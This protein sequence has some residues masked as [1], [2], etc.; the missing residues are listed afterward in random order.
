MFAYRKLQEVAHFES[1]KVETIQH[2]FDRS[3]AKYE[4]QNSQLHQKIKDLKSQVD[5]KNL[6]LKRRFN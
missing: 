1:E 6:S 2:E 3:I 5:E 4:Q